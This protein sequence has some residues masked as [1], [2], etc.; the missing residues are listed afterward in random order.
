MMARNRSKNMQFCIIAL[1]V[2]VVIISYSNHL[3]TADDNSGSV[4]I[5]TNN[6]NIKPKWSISSIIPDILTNKAYVS[7][8]EKATHSGHVC[9]SSQ[10]VTDF[11]TH[12]PHTINIF[13]RLSI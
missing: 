12:E 8:G 7:E 11:C 2:C 9:Q 13:H 10:N 5:N 1:I 3:N 4:S 6:A